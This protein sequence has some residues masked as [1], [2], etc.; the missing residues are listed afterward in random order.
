[1]FRLD[2]RPPCSYVLP[3]S[4]SDAELLIFWGCCSERKD[5]YLFSYIEKVS[6]PLLIYLWGSPRQEIFRPEVARTRDDARINKLN[7]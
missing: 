3:S 5:L 1:M 7:G 6:E 2:K 4:D